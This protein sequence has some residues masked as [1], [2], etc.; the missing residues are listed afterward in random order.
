LSAASSLEHLTDLADH[1]AE[2]PDFAAQR[3]E[4]EAALHALDSPDSATQP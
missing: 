4:T 3:A 1:F 2:N